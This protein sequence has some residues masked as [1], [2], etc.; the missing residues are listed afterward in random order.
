MDKETP[1]TKCEALEKINYFLE[2]RGICIDVS[3]LIELF[4]WQNKLLLWA[5]Q[6]QSRRQAS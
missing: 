6:E 5:L 2:K 1:V 4:E 3:T